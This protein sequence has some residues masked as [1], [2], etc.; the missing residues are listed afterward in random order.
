MIK[1]AESEYYTLVELAN[2]LKCSKISARRYVTKHNMPLRKI[3]RK[4]YVSKS[5]ILQFLNVQQ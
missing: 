1:F 3:G 2:I 5:S 4:V